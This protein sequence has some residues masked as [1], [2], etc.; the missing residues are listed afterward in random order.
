MSPKGIRLS[1][2]LRWLLRKEQRLDPVLE[3]K[4][5][6]NRDAL[7]KQRREFA[8]KNQRELNESAPLNSD[9]IVTRAI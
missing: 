6:K 1:S 9:R 8:R 4:L 5:Q 7:E 2:A 3:R